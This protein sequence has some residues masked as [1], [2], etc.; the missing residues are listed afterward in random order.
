MKDYLLKKN[1]D[2]EF[3]YVD[4][5][6]VSWDSP[7]EW[8]WVGVLGGCGCG[9]SDYLSEMAWKILKNFANDDFA[10]RLHVYDKDKYEILAHWMDDKELIE[11]GT[12]IGG[13][14]LTDYG[15]KV[16]E[17]ILHLEDRDGRSK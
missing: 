6:G 9:H 3:G 12:G 4:N 1:D 13:S 2:S 16:Y 14:W 15:K 10:G 8:L 17:T 11:H 5:D 7:L